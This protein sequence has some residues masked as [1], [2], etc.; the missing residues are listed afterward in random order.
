M[1]CCS[2]LL[3]EGKLNGF[4]I[5]HPDGLADPRGYLRRLAERTGGAWVVVEKILEGDEEL[6]ADWPCAGH[7]RL[8][9]SAARRWPV[10]RP[11]RRRTAV[12]PSTR[13]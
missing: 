12:L 13:S 2:R 6:P 5:D 3:H 7:Y 4:R 8:R 11:G 1:S 10:R 9:R